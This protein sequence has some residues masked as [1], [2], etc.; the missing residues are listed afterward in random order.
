MN[1][2][3]A[4][5]PDGPEGCGQVNKSS[6][7]EIFAFLKSHGWVCDPRGEYMTGEMNPEIEDFFIKNSISL[8]KY[9]TENQELPKPK[10]IYDQQIKP[11]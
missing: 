5:L 10:L 6:D 8:P 7:R 2:C 4:E 1:P 3:S 9:P 11:C